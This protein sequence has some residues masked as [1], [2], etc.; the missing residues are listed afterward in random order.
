MANI[1]KIKARLQT[2]ADSNGVRKDIH[3]ITT[4]DEV[5]VPGN[6][7]EE[8]KLSDVLNDIHAKIEI[9]TEQPLYPTVWFRTLTDD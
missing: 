6:D 5:I 2:P 9:G 8:K 4:T 1:E 3:L 7:G